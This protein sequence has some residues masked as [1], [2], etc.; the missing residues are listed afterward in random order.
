[1]EKCLTL[2]WHVGEGHTDYVETVSFS[3]DGTILASGAYDRIVRLWDVE[4]RQEIA[5][6]EGHEGGVYSVSFSLDG[7]ILASSAN[8]G[9][10][11][12]WDVETREQIASLDEHE[13]S[14]AP[15]V[16]F[17][18][19]G[20]T[21]ASGSF[22]AT[23]RLW[24]IASRA[25]IA[26][27]EHEGWV[28][29]VSFSPDGKTLASAST[30]GTVWLWD[31]ESRAPLATLQ[32]HA[33]NLVYSVSFSPD[34]TTLASG[35]P[36]KWVILWDVSAWTQPRPQTLT[37]VPG[38]GHQGPAGAALTKPFAVLV[39]DQ[40]G[41]LLAGVTV[42]FAVTAGGGT[43]SVE[44]AATDADGRAAT[45]LTLGPQPGTN[46]VEATVD[47]LE[48]VIFTATGLAVAQSLRKPSGDEQEG[49]AGAALGEPFV[50]E[51]RD[52]NGNPLAGA[53]VTFAVTAGG[54]T[55]SATTV[56]TDADG[57]AATALTLGRTPGTTTV[58]ATVA[59]LEPVTFTATG[60]AVPRTPGQASRLRDGRTGGHGLVRALRGRDQRSERL[61]SCRGDR[62]L[63]GYRRWGDSHHNHRYY[64][65]RR[66]R[67][68]HPD[69]G[70][71]SR[72]EHR[73]GN[74]GRS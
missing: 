19:D 28:Y 9:T 55:L 41:D 57:R 3:P 56:T 68:H 6:L 32:G 29:S 43:V 20:K 40:F 5:T 18:P 73:D 22:D 64:G 1:M 8:D 7:T 51:V 4:T 17:S 69:P 12:L 63:F 33:A 52:Q 24:D 65:C 46:T 67:R 42:T 36:D 34:G 30:A 50:V 37:M 23:V 72:T 47:R 26:S 11:R 15:S 27:F 39:L 70:P 53:Q 71:R 25:P 21:L 66:T 49:A 35:S 61:P 13:G 14:L 38:R 10:I 60:V 58:R 45:T 16:S 54:G 48:P 59:D 2:Y 44:T 31:V 62:H 74:R